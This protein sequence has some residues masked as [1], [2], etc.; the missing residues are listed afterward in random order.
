MKEELITASD[1]A[2]F[3]RVKLPTIRLWTRQGAP[4][5]R[6]GRLVRF[7]ASEVEGW[8]RARS[9]KAEVRDEQHSQ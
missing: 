9:E 8:L 1:T 5:L 4:C 6:A 2:A 3:F 7:R